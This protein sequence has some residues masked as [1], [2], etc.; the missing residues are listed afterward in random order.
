[1]L[2]RPSAYPANAAKSTQSSVATIDTTAELSKKRPN[3]FSEKT[4]T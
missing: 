4:E 3:G 2:S 1:M